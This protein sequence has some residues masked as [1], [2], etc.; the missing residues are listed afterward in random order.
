MK[1]KC[2]Y[3]VGSKL[4]SEVLALG[5]T[6]DTVFHVATGKTYDAYAM[7]ILTCEVPGIIPWTAVIHYLIIDECG[8]PTWYPAPLFAVEDS[9]LPSCWHFA[10][11]GRGNDTNVLAVWGYPEI[12]LDVDHFGA[13]VDGET[14]ARDVFERRRQEINSSEL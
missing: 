3:A 14:H 7:C 12:A 6:N 4:P 10:N 1:V 8:A 9:E 5:N 13:L 11:W 2:T